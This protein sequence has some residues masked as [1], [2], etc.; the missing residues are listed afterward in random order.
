MKSSLRLLVATGV[1]AIVGANIA[2]ASAVYA[3]DYVPPKLK[4]MGTTSLPIAGSGK[5]ILKVLVKPDGS[6]TVQNVIKSTNPA[7]NAAAIDLA[8]HSSYTPAMRGGKPTLAFYDFTLRFS[9]K[10]VAGAGDSASSTSAGG[11][12]ASKIAGMLRS[13][14]YNG[15]KTAAVAYLAAHPND[16]LVNSYLG[17]ANTFLNDDIAAAQ[18]FDKA[19]TIPKNYLSV[20]GQAYSLAAIQSTAQNPQ[21]ALAYAQ[22]AVQLHADGNSYFALGVAQL[23]NNDAAS[24]VTN[25]KKAH[26]LAFAASAKA[27]VK[28]KV[29]IDTQLLA[30]YSQLKDTAN[31][32]ATL[33][34]IKQLDPKSNAGARIVAQQAYDQANVD[35]GA[36]K[37]ADAIKD[38]ER[39][40]IADPESAV[41]GYANAALLMSHLDKPDFKAMSDE[42][43]K[44]LAAKADDPL[45]NYAKGVALVNLGQQNKDEASKKK[46]IEY[47]NKADAE[48]KAANMIGLATAIE[49]FIK[50]IK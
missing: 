38:Y 24:A 4:H 47:L 16:D 49:N 12:Q 41:T 34:E 28:D 25:L 22:K 15:A 45:A 8:K 39:G 27:S 42:A 2:P 21:Q 50:S 32:N 6:F 13:G 7:D 48:A 18:A 33:A 26:D 9:G 31:M 46:G 19:S 20:A 36:G 30:A 10:S 5:V 35:A 43:D 23:H 17:L 40:A 1:V 3:T 14:N 11:S 37:T 29:G 44:A